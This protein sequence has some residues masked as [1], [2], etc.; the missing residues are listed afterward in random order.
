MIWSALIEEDWGRRAAA[1][2]LEAAVEY[3][4]HPGGNDIHAHH[5]RT[6]SGNGNG[7]GSP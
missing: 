4:D 1:A 3:F 6:K 2:L 7:N 5:Q